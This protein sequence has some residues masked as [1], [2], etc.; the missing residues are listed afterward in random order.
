MAE[1]LTIMEARIVEELR[2]GLLE[3]DYDEASFHE[4]EPGV[5]SERIM[6]W[7]DAI[8]V[9]RQDKEKSNG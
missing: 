9:L 3:P 6:F 7:R 5:L 1:T 8:Q 2:Q 4:G